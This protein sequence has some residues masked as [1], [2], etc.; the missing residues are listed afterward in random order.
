MYVNIFY[1]ELYTYST[2]TH[3]QI[4]CRLLQSHGAVNCQTYKI[5]RFSQLYSYTMYKSLTKTKNNKKNPLYKTIYTLYTSM[6]IL[7]A[8][9]TAGI[10]GVVTPPRLRDLYQGVNLVPGHCYVIFKHNCFSKWSQAHSVTTTP[11]SKHI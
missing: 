3:T 8:N 11:P 2:Y 7:R 9:F 10:N 6:T 1:I 4:W 5:N